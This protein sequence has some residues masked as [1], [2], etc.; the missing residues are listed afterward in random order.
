M[1]HIHVT[2]TNEVS[3]FIGESDFTV[4]ISVDATKVP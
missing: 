1:V 3:D 2:L 4:S